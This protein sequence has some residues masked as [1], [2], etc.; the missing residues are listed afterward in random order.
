MTTRRDFLMTATAGLTL[1]FFLP[2][3]SRLGVVDTAA[4]APAA[5]EVNTWL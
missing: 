1:G 4:A 3:L 5:T 2:S